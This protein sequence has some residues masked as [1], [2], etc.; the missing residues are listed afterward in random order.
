MCLF[1][2]HLLKLKQALKTKSLNN[3]NLKETQFI[4][5]KKNDGK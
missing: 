4:A 1:K 2:A 5:N 3:F